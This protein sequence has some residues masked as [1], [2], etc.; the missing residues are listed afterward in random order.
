MALIRDIFP[1]LQ[2]DHSVRNMLKVNT[3]RTQFKH[4]DKDIQLLKLTLAFLCGRLCGIDAGIR[5]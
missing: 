4:L 1:T 5:A 3:Q 2:E